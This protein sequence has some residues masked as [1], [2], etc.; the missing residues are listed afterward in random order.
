[1]NVCAICDEEAGE[2]AMLNAV[3]PEVVAALSAAIRRGDTAEAE[4]QLDL[5]AEGDRRLEWAIANGRIAGR[6][7]A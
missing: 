3:D 4:H 7:A 1:M 6:K 5:L 2:L